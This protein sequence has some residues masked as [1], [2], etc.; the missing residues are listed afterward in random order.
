MSRKNPGMMVRFNP[1]E[2]MAS[3]KTPLRK[4][5]AM[6]AKTTA[7]AAVESWIPLV[8]WL[9]DARERAIAS[10]SASPERKLVMYMPLVPR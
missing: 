1:G 3:T 9:S 6:I 4:V 10:T 2:P 8:A 5:L 7:L